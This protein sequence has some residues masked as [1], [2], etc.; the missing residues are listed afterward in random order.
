MKIVLLDSTVSNFDIEKDILRSLGEK[1]QF[2]ESSAL[3]SEEELINLC[4]DADAIIVNRS[5][6]T[7]K[8][9]GALTK[10]KVIAR[11]GVGLD[12]V[13]VAE[14]TKRG[15]AVANTPGY[16]VDEVSE[17]AVMMILMLMRMAIHAHQK[18]L[19]DSWS[20]EDVK[21][22]ESISG[23]VIGVLGFGA[24]GQAF[25]KKIQ[26]FSPKEI[27]VVSKHLGESEAEKLGLTLS[28]FEEALR[29]SDVISLHWPMSR[30]TEKIINK[31]TLSMM[32]KNALLINTSRG[33][34]ID[35]V[36]LV[37]ALEQ[38]VIKGAGIDVFENEPFEKDH[39]IKKLKNV[40]LSPHLA[41][42]SK[43]S[44]NKMKTLAANG[45]LDIL[46]KG[47]SKYKI[48]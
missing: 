17:V 32:K 48:N 2:F 34:L 29:E 6:M 31:K 26:A 13:D 21:E 15:V 39:P 9:I 22:I 18:A 12:N 42:Y 1:T 27:K 20:L 28:G 19:N 36:D 4:H 38:G 43:E 41:F 35:E 8:V 10:C 5:Y 7:K 14:A 24:I 47:K 23:K 16:C 30:E 33:R 46:T 25:T 11:Y 44:L 37:E 3:L 45:V 40:V